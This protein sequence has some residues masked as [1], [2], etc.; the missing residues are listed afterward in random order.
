MNS[1]LVELLGAVGPGICYA[2]LAVALFGLRSLFRSFENVL[3]GNA[4][5]HERMLTKINDHESRIVRVEA[6]L[7][8]MRDRVS[9]KK[10]NSNE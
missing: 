3:K 8:E 2:L 4:E 10:D 6:L 1:H 5:A 9:F 7:P